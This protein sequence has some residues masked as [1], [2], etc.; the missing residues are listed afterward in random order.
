MLNR[1]LYQNIRKQ[2]KSKQTVVSTLPIQDV[3]IINEETGYTSYFVKSKIDELCTQNKILKGVL[4]VMPNNY[5]SGIVKTEFGIIHIPN[6]VHLNR[7]LNGNSVYVNLLSVKQKNQEIF[8]WSIDQQQGD[9]HI[10][11]TLQHVIGHI[12]YTQPFEE[13][14]LQCFLDSETKL[15][16]ILKFIPIDKRYPTIVVSDQLADIIPNQIF[17]IKILN[18]K[19]QMI[20]P[21]GEIISKDE[22]LQLADLSQIAD[23]VMKV[24]GIPF[25]YKGDLDPLILQEIQYNEQQLIDDVGLPRSEVFGLNQNILNNYQKQIEKLSKRKL[26]F[27]SQNRRDFTNELVFT[28]DP[29]TAKDFDDAC[30]IKLVAS[31]GSTICLK[32]LSKL[33]SDDISTAFNNAIG[34]EI[35]VHIA[36]VTHYV[37]PNSQIDLYAQSTKTSVYLTDRCCPMIPY[38]LAD[39]LC[40]LNPAVPRYTFSVVFRLNF[41]GELL[42]QT[43]WFGKSVIFSHAR[44]DYVGAQM[45]LDN[46]LTPDN[47]STEINN[48][49]VCLNCQSAIFLAV[50]TMNIIAVVLRKQ[51]E[52]LGALQLRGDC[53]SFSINKTNNVVSIYGPEDAVD[54][55]HLIEEFMVAANCLVGIRLVQSF[56]GCS[57]LRKHPPPRKDDSVNKIVKNF[58]K[59]SFTNGSTVVKSIVNI[60][61]NMQHKI[62]FNEQ[63]WSSKSQSMFLADSCFATN[64]LNKAEYIIGLS[65]E[66]SLF[67][68]W[69]IHAQMYMHFTSPIRR[70][71]DDIAHR[72]LTE[73][74]KI[75]STGQSSIYCP[76]KLQI[77]ELIKLYESVDFLPPIDYLK[78]CDENQTLQDTIAHSDQTRDIQAD[79]LEDVEDGKYVNLH[80]QKTMNMLKKSIENL[81]ERGQQ[82]ASIYEEKQDV[83]PAAQAFREVEQ[84]LKNIG[85]PLQVLIDHTKSCNILSQ[86]ADKASSLHRSIMLHFWTNQQQKEV[87]ATCFLISAKDNIL[88]FFVPQFG[89]SFTC[90]SNFLNKEGCILVEKFRT[91]LSLNQQ[92]ATEKQEVFELFSQVA[93]KSVSFEFLAPV[94]VQIISSQS[95]LDGVDYW[96]MG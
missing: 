48:F 90:N 67:S 62:Q 51:R 4:Q 8:N 44:L 57:I 82:T 34:Y 80:S 1:N 70:Y 69:G 87:F 13:I 3:R 79:V 58:G 88:L 10:T 91:D 54:A 76:N 27:D 71:A 39:G 9:E 94:S 55:H 52:A 74:L 29:D 11:Q 33:N 42:P 60:A 19:P 45:I 28:I 85:L 23:Y 22:V 41:V 95:V 65:S 78:I 64:N 77:K 56:P 2:E 63:F 93:V 43:V 72:L 30:H 75:E 68:H 92:F 50:Q 59:L 5:S 66:K 6:K 81:L 86:A 15:A 16:G 46:K 61:S 21:A 17:N 53:T 12:V 7:A 14:V 32:Q 84:A 96:L 25:N 37:K 26:I 36:D 89:I 83:S 73:S 35:G 20:Y 24:N 31:N 38:E 40:S 47:N 49:P 18:W